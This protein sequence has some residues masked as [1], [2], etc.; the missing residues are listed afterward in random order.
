MTEKTPMSSTQEIFNRFFTTEA[1]TLET[2]NEALA[3]KSRIRTTATP[4]KSELKEKESV[5]PKNI[6]GKK[7]F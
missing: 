1:A 6:T 4:L 2:I 5:P 7:S 3:N